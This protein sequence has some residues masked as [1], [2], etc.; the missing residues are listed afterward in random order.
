MQHR[1][2]KI[3]QKCDGDDGCE[4]DFVKIVDDND[5]VVEQA[6]ANN[7]AQIMAGT[8][9]LWAR[10][11]MSNAVDVL[12]VDE[13]G[14]MSLA[15]VLAASPAADSVVLFGD[16]QQLGSTAVWRSSA[17]RGSVGAISSIKRHKTNNAE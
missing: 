8:V 14:Q 2:S 6:L 5:K 15:N 12:F 13:A 3:L 11:E 7:E 1:S 4:H 17:G 9:W 10:A 16:P